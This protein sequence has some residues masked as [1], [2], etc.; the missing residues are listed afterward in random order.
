[1]KIASVS[2]LHR[3]SYPKKPKNVVVVS[4]FA[5]QNKA[6]Y[7]KAN[8]ISFKNYPFWLNNEK[9]RIESIQEYLDFHLNFAK[10]DFRSNN[11]YA[12]LVQS[13]ES[14]QAFVS[15][16]YSATRLTYYPKGGITNGEFVNL[17]KKYEIKDIDEILVDV[18]KNTHSKFS[19]VTRTSL[20]IRHDFYKHLIHELSKFDPK[21]DFLKD[22]DDKMVKIATSYYKRYDKQFDKYNKQIKNKL[23]YSS[24]SPMIKF[25]LQEEIDKLPIEKQKE[26]DEKFNGDYNKM[27]IDFIAEGCLESRAPEKYSTGV[28][29]ALIHMLNRYEQKKKS[30]I[31]PIA[32]LSRRLRIDDMDK[33]MQA[34]NI[35]AIYSYPKTQSCSKTM[36]PAETC[37]AD[38]NRSMNVILRIHP[39]SKKTKAFELPDIDVNKETNYKYYDDMYERKFRQEVLYPSNTKFKVLGAC[40]YVKNNYDFRNRTAG[41][42]YK[43]IID[44]QEV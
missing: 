41:D 19:D 28:D 36:Q 26:I 37:F 20:E 23:E 9:P 39:K 1:M 8:A 34:F 14:M 29:T 13:N 12:D 21:E 22:G 33:F 15:G 43:T 27:M 7:N 44:L 11:E 3:V 5:M 42:Y 32:P 6:E 16:L 4:D 10:Q 35:G 31:F 18:G 2:Y 25:D 40:R 24:V 30:K 17:L 38:F